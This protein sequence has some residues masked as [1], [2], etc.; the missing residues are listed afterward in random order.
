M[1]KEQKE[2]DFRE[3]FV[4]DKNVSL[5]ILLLASFF[6]YRIATTEGLTTSV[7]FGVFRSFA[8]FLFYALSYFIFP[9]AVFL[10]WKRKS[11]GWILAS[12]YTIYSIVINLILFIT[13]LFN[14]YTSFLILLILFFPI[15][16]YCFVQYLLCRKSMLNTYHVS[17][18]KAVFIIAIT[19]VFSVASSFYWQ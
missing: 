6:L 15:A 12:V 1:S 14:S 10:F 9:V 17:D 19:I 13:T 3:V 11:S 2:T 16:F 7:I 4:E 8:D 5:V 18:R